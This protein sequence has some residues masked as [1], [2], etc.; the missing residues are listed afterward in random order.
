MSAISEKLKEKNIK[1]KFELPD[2][3]KNEELV[4]CLKNNPTSVIY[5]N[6]FESGDIWAKVKGCE[7][8]PIESRK[9]CCKNCLKYTDDGCDHHLDGSNGQEKPFVCVYGPTPKA[10]IP[11]CQM[12]FECVRGKQ[13]GNI[14]KMNRDAKSK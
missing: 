6:I 12:E 10:R 8:C 3:Y 1:I 2:E 5:F 11:Y 13:K 4:L 7:G 9:K 14:I